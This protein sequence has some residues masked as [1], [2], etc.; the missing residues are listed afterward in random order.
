MLY[1]RRNVLRDASRLCAGALASSTLLP[2]LPAES[3]GIWPMGIRIFFVGTW[4]FC[5]DPQNTN[6]KVL[7]ITVD[8]S[9]GHTFPYG[10]WVAGGIDNNGTS[11]P[12]NPAA[13]GAA[14]N[15]YDV[16]VMGTSQPAKSLAGLFAAATANC[17]FNYIPNDLPLTFTSGDIRVISVP[18]PTRLLVVGTLQGGIITSDQQNYPLLGTGLAGMAHVFDYQGASSLAFM[19]KTTNAS[20]D[21][22]ANFHFH[23]V[24]PGCVYHGT[25]MFAAL[26]KD[27]LGG[28]Y[29]IQ[30]SGV[31]PDL[32]PV[33]GGCVPNGFDPAELDYPGQTDPC[34][35]QKKQQ[36][37]EARSKTEPQHETA[38]THTT[39]SCAGAGLGVGGGGS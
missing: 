13:A 2:L 6:S 26:I 3:T 28:N 30:L 5:K 25:E 34:F 33:L 23:T 14:R 7:A 1:T 11:L 19:G 16:A 4:L 31:D 18:F 37:A 12:A 27:V 36:T 9:M 32:P 35:Q 21:S 8:A 24:P 22:S 10:A 20:Q 39:A 17:N 15:S 29:T 38:L